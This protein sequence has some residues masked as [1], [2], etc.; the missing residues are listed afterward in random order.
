MFSIPGG[1]L[2]LEILFAPLIGDHGSADRL[3]GIVQPTATLAHLE[4]RPVAEVSVR[5]AAAAGTRAP[6][7]VLR[8]ATID[9]Q[10]IA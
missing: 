3:V 1:Q 7:P 2:P 10:R 5:M 9:G 8:L 6:R 4:G